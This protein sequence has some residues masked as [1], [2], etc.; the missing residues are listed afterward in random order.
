MASDTRSELPFVIKALAKFALIS[1]GGFGMRFISR[2]LLSLALLVAATAAWAGETGSISGVV[3][4][5][6]GL[7][8]PGAMVKVS[9]PQMP[10]GY[11]TVSRASGTY[12]FP[13]LI[14][15]AYTV[16]AELKGLGRVAKK[17]NVSVDN[18]YQIE[19]VLVQTA[20]AEVVV[21]AV[22][23]EVDKKSTEVNSNFVS[24]EI[25][26]LPIARNYSGLISLIPGA[27][28]ED[29][30]AGI[31]SVG[32]GTR[33]EN[34]Y[35]IDGVNISNPFAAYIGIDT[36]EL[37]I[38][39]VNI[40]RAAITAEFGRTSGVIVNAVTKSGTNEIKG[41]VRGSMSPASFAA[42]NNQ[43]VVTQQTDTYNG[44]AGVGFPILKDTLFGYAS[45]RY[46]KTT[47]S[48][49]TATLEGVT[50]TQ[51]DGTATATDYF[52]KLT[53]LL[54]QSL[55]VNAGF[56]GLPNKSDNQF[57]SVYDA[58][59]AAYGN[60]VAN[61][62]LNASADWF[63]SKD[64]VLEARYVH[65][66]E[67]DASTAQTLLNDR[68]LTI[69]PNNLWKYG[70]FSD[71]TRN[72]GNAGV[73]PYQVDGETFKRNEVKLTASHF[74]DIGNTQNQVKIGGGAEIIDYTFQRPS[75]GWGTLIYSST[76]EVRARY[77]TT[78]SKQV[79]A[80]RTYSLFLQDNLTAGQL[81]IT[82]GV[83]LNRED[84]SQTCLAGTV[85]GPTTAVNTADT[86][87]NFLGFNWGDEVQPRFG[88]AYNANLFDGDKFYGSWGIYQGIDAKS[89]IRSQAPFRVRED[90]SFFSRTTG[91]FLREQI[92][93]SSAGHQ[94]PQGLTAPSY[95]EVV[96]GYAAPVGREFSVDLFYQYKTLK[97]PLE[98]TPIDPAK[99]FGSFVLHN[100]PNA[101]RIYSGATIDIT[102]RYS[103][104][105]FL[106][107][108]YTYSKLYGNFDDD[109]SVAQYNNSSSLEDEPGLYTDDP[110]SNRSGLLGQDRPHIFKMLASYDLPFGFTLGGFFRI[111][112]GTPWQAQGYTASQYTAFGSVGA[113]YLEPAGSRRLPT[114]TNF[115]LLGAY[116]FK[117]GGDMSVRLEGRVQNLFNTQT[118]LNVNRT[119]YT[120]PYKDPADPGT[121]NVLGPQQTKQLNPL[122][123]TATAWASPRRFT[124][125]A[126][127]NF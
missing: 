17:L 104:G 16:E 36:N 40:K 94:I 9:G 33:E 120:D 31:V 24:A 66:T 116:T 51:P 75:N 121:S 22:N 53:A 44:S 5:G 39:D 57:S 126:Y 123:G 67:D 63:A 106:N 20:A 68:P 78:T 97:S 99:Y 117:F 111:Q 42:N 2:I 11:T 26:Q 88:F 28:A 1:G 95:Q 113:R 72:G 47:T 107:A 10:A 124:L 30:G 108:N 81:S 6:S 38:A 65:T 109:F 76:T 12:A 118:V 4:D 34:K 86:R 84:F 29:G 90:Q 58:A 70:G 102:K 122:F 15:G 105:W 56:R 13:K 101:R 80:A 54:G 89:A 103:H 7:A 71:P 100:F 110:A 32:G 60:D 96:L 93:G 41:T 37:D 25:R 21:T 3:K 50:T 125:T 45:G 43:G 8:V 49:L 55:Q 127:F 87:Y 35:L 114:R 79:G 69:D 27:G 73:Y 18:D 14:P 48:G 74:L 64:T 52:G 61:Y 59:S 85:C 82:A 77:Y 23:A 119:E 62:V 19:L 46:A 83:L 115:D 98:D 92:R 112:S 91:A